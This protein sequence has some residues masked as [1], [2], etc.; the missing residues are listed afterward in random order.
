[1]NWPQVCEGIASVNR[2]FVLYRAISS[3]ELPVSA[4]RPTRR[5]ELRNSDGPGGHVLSERLSHKPRRN[6]SYEQGA[7]REAIGSLMY[8]SV[9][10]LPDITF[11]ISTLSQF[12]DNLRDI[13]CFPVNVTRV[14]KKLR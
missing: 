12:F 4:L 8:A 11:A 1:M 10:T 6:R 7:Y 13:H 9:A 14:V 2:L 5:E 3:L